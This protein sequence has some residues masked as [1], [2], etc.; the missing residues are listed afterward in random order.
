M[1][2]VSVW[3]PRAGSRRGAGTIPAAIATIIVSPTARE[4]PR[5]IDAMIPDSAAGTTTRD[6]TVIFDA[7]SPYAPSRSARGTADIA[8]S[9]TDAMIGTIMTPTTMPADSAL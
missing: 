7:P 9:E 3:M 2:P 4:T 6:A 1:Y 5:M 8:S